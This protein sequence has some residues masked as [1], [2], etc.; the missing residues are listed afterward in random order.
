MLDAPIE[1]PPSPAAVLSRRLV[2][3]EQVA[4]LA[5]PFGDQSARGL[6]V[7]AGGFGTRIGT[8]RDRTELLWPASLLQLQ[9]TIES[10]RVSQRAERQTWLDWEFGVHGKSPGEALFLPASMLVWY[11]EFEVL[12]AL[13]LCSACTVPS[14]DDARWN[15]LLDDL[16]EAVPPTIHWLD[17][18]ADET[19]RLLMH[20][21]LNAEVAGNSQGRCFLRICSN[22]AANPDPSS[23]SRATSSAGVAQ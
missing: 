16:S 22:Q 9:T 7:V 23:G 8:D 20:S 4:T 13:G 21:V 19:A 11:V 2:L 17:R 6:L 1:H 5:P 18:P 12:Q 10:T 14:S 15:D 3:N